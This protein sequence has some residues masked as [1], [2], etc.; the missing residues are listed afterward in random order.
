MGEFYAEGIPERI[1]HRDLEYVEKPT[2][3]TVVKGMRRTGKTYVTYERIRRLL[4]EGVPIG[5]IVHLN[6]GLFCIIGHG[7]RNEKRLTS[8]LSAA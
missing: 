1:V 3:A 6:F 4:D 7:R 2:A 8:Q 5:R